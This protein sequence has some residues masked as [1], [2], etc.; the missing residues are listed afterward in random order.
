MIGKITLRILA[1]IGLSGQLGEEMKGL[2]SSFRMILSVVLCLAFITPAMELGFVAALYM[3]LSPEKRTALLAQLDRFGLCELHSSVCAPENAVYWISGGAGLLLILYIG[4]R[5]L[6]SYCLAKLNYV[7]YTRYSTRLLV[8]YLNMP[9][10]RAM[11]VDKNKAVN[12]IVIEVAT[13]GAEATELLLLLSASG[14]ALFF[15]IGSA[16]LSSTLLMVCLGVGTGMFFLNRHGYKAARAIGKRRIDAQN[17]SLARVYDLL[18]G[19]RTIKIEGAEEKIIAAEEKAIRKR[20][21]WRYDAKWNVL[22]VSNLAQGFTYLIL[23]VVVF[24]TVV[25]MRMDVAIMLTFMVMVARLQRVFITAQTHWMKIRQNIG[26]LETVTKIMAYC[27]EEQFSPLS[28][29][30]ETIDGLSVKFDSVSFRYENGP[31][32]YQDLSFELNAGDRVLLQGASG[33]GKSTLLQLLLGLLEP[34]EGIVWYGD[35]P[36]NLELFAQIRHL[37]AYAAPDL[38]VFRSSIRENLELTQALS[39]EE[40]LRVIRRVK[41]DKVVENLEGG[42]DGFV[43][44]NGCN[45]SLGERQ[46]VMLARILLKNPKLLVLDEAT[47]NLDIALE[48]DILQELFT[49]LAEDAIVILI[50]HKKPDGIRFNRSMFL[51]GGKLHEAAANDQLKQVVHE[52]AEVE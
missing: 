31:W 14:T 21:R 42:I 17:F 38:H 12:S 46:R 52:V 22:S 47:S 1:S 49:S 7:A 39:D 30:Q 48:D 5:L 40:I 50:A 41:L 44:E 45:L 23:F 33:Q 26:G 15:I 51:K 4:T 32:I 35:K 18:E 16:S 19:F 11:R 28:G 27:E 34:T 9:P 3:L 10:M 43:G 36:L 25:V 37:I 2:F 20:H 8:S 13:F 24:I 6:Q 29:A